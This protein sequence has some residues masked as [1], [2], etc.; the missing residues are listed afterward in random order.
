MCG[1][2][3]DGS[4]KAVERVAKLP[5][6]FVLF[7]LSLFF[8]LN[9]SIL[10]SYRQRDSVFR[11]KERVASLVSIEKGW[12]Q[13]ACLFIVQSVKWGEFTS[14]REEGRSLLFILVCVCVH[15]RA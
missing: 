14:N 1:V 5:A 3:W 6:L 2:G 10:M 8:Y 13:S 15:V 12:R 9:K 4:Q 7:S 11:R